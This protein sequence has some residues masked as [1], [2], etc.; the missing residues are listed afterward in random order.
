MIARPTP[1][2]AAVMSE[3]GFKV[4]HVQDIDFRSHCPLLRDCLAQLSAWSNGNPEHHPVLITINAKDEAID[5][6]GFA[7]P[8]E[9]DAAAWRALDETLRQGLGPRLFEPDSLRGKAD[10]LS[11]AIASGW[12]T[13]AEMRG[14]F[15]VV[16][17]HD[18]EKRASYIAGHPALRGRAMF[19]NAPPDTPESA[20]LIINDPV[21]R[22]AEITAAVEQGYLV[23]T[24]ADADTR[25]A[26]SGDYTR[27]RKAFASGAQ[28]VTTDY[29]LPER[30]FGHDFQVRFP[31]GGYVRCNPV[32]RPDCETRG[33]GASMLAGTSWRLVDFL[34]M[35]DAIGRIEP[36][37][38]VLYTL[39]LHADGS[40]SM[41]LNCN[42]ARG[43][44][45]AE[46]SG[47]QDSGS[48]VFGPLASTR[49]FCPPP[50]MDAR[51][52]RDMEYVRSF[53]SRDD[54]LYLSLY[55]DGGIYQFEP[56]VGEP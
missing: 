27:M 2:D 32:L 15:L 9:F 16:L 47:S 49:A 26:R 25:E 6:S 50:N 38:D 5:Q 20:V 29:Y 54:R 8:L 51:V 10:S 39:H 53:V 33:S 30:R 23:R 22:H 14:K 44:W 45:Q 31:G 12:P 13:L 46:S 35:D 19:V 17:D 42:R 36:P 56:L 7:T 1:Y 24:R 52:T 28:V 43:T 3:P 37:D 41:R 21:V 40:V 48:F 18:G 34:S 55:A 4:M 11:A